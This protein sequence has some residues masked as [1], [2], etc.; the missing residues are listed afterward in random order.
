LL[1]D[2]GSPFC[3]SSDL[4]S[5]HFWSSADDD[6]DDYEVEVEAELSQSPK[7]GI[8]ISQCT[9]NPKRLLTPL[10]LE[11]H[12]RRSLAHMA[13]QLQVVI[14]KGQALIIEWELHLPDYQSFVKRRLPHYGVIS[15]RRQP[16]S[17][18]NNLPW[19]LPLI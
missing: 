2:L 5:P 7:N 4:S 13:H 19:P 18:V 11:P 12:S 8:S 16:H 3:Y 14:P 1:P 15:Q 10:G 6:D 9:C 17:L